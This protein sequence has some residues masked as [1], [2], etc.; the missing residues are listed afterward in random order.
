MNANALLY[1]M[2]AR[3]QG[4]W[5]QFR[6]AVEELGLNETPDIE[7]E[8]DDAPDENALPLYQTLRFNLQRLGHA[9]FFAGAGGA[10]WRVTPPSLAMTQRGSDFLGIV[11]GARSLAL[12]NRIHD[13][14]GNGT[15]A[16]RVIP[17]YPDQLLFVATD[18][19]AIAAAAE[20]AGLAVQTDAPAALLASLPAVDDG[21]VRH[22]TQLP[23]G[24]DWKVERFS[25]EV[26]GWRAATLNDAQSAI[27]DLFRFS[28]LHQRHVVFCGKG[29][30]FRIPGQAG[31]YLALRGRRR[32]V[33]SYDAGAQI[34]SV[35]G[36]CRPPFLVE[37]ALILCSGVPPTYDRNSRTGTLSY[38]EIPHGVAALTAGLLR[39]GLR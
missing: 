14:A 7:E 35:P 31:K 25:C 16:R 9:E 28:L 3:G 26:L 19:A 1:W 10:D 11:A 20:R 37:R 34:L 6:A 15:V 30:A 24:A 21:R 13:A 29:R 4:S 39:Q 5:Q 8:D 18:R 36:S 27:G 12:L 17:G 32:Q 22:L 33:F 38:A 2:S 23:F